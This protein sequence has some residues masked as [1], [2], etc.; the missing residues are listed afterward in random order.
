MEPNRAGLVVRSLDDTELQDYGVE[1]GVM[2][3]AATGAAAEARIQPGD[4]VISING[5]E[6][7]SQSGLDELAR[8]L[9]ADRAIPVLVLRGE[10]QNFFTLRILD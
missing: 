5:Q 2:V 1:N 6:I 8:E 9:P 3:E 7:S 4:I 10:A